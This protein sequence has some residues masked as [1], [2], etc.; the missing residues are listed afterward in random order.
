MLA[1][2]LLV[3]TVGHLLSGA[4]VHQGLDSLL[5]LSSRRLELV[6][7]HVHY[8]LVDGRELSHLLEVNFDVSSFREK[9]TDELEDIVETILE[10]VF[11]NIGSFGHLS[12]V[13]LHKWSHGWVDVSLKLSVLWVILKSMVLE[14]GLSK[15]NEDKLLVVSDLL[16]SNE[17]KKIH[18][19]GSVDLDLAE[20]KL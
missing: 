9:L 4:L 12:V 20:G 10:D 18:V 15:L 16:V 13:G 11:L 1:H 7:G 5:A 19:D 3:V 14:E 2:L 8:L 6:D 17:A